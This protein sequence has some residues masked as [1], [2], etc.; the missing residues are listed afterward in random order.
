MS[1]KKFFILF[2]S[3]NPV[4]FARLRTDKEAEKI[5]EKLRL[6]KLY[7]NFS[8]DVRMATRAEDFSQALLDKTPNIVHFAGHG[9]RSGEI[10]LEDEIGNSHPVSPESLRN[11]FALVSDHVDC[12]ILNACYSEAQASA[13][14]EHIKFVIG[15]SYPVMDDAAIAF[16]VGFYQ[17]LGIGKTIEEAY[18]FGCVQVGLTVNSKVN[19]ENVIPIIKKNKY[20]H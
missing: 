14:A 5:R 17:A 2:L 20:E 7:Q 12:V 8:F 3:S 13:I 15:T 18:K 1:E 10:C 19:R 9:L 4:D 16:S 6:A 11:L